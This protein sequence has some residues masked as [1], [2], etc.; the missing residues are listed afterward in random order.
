MRFLSFSVPVMLTG[1]MG[2]PMREAMS[3]APGRAGCIRAVWAP[4]A[5]RE[6]DQGY[7]LFQP[8]FRLA[9]GF[10]VHP[11]PLYRESAEVLHPET[12]PPVMPEL[13]FSHEDAF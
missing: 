13:F 1:R 6:H 7:A 4:A 11:A 12:R 9:D 3:A 8:V 2:T 5:F 10:P